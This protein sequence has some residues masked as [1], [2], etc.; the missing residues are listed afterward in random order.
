MGKIR[1]AAAIIACRLTRLMLRAVGKGGT[2]LPGMVAVKLYKGILSELSKNVNTI[3]V[4][5][6]NGKTTSSRMIEQTLI[7]S[8]R[9][10]FCNKSGANMLGGIVAEFCENSTIR[11]RKNMTGRLSNVMRQHLEPFQ[12]I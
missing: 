11:E 5:G 1:A 7:E 2:S 12:N 6:T 9:T 10:Y 3:I 4:T 8:D